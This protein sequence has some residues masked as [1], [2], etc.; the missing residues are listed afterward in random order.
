MYIH[1]IRNTKLRCFLL[2]HF[3]FS[4]LHFTLITASRKAYFDTETT[5]IRNDLYLTY[6]CFETHKLCKI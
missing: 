5:K 1:N 6:L 4:V 2:L 3:T